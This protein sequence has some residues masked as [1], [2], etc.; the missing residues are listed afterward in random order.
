MVDPDSSSPQFATAFAV[1]VTFHVQSKRRLSETLRIL[2]A[3]R[4]TVAARVIAE[5]GDEI[6]GAGKL[7]V[8]GSHV[9]RPLPALAPRRALE[10]VVVNMER[11]RIAARA[12]RQRPQG[13]PNH[14]NLKR[15]VHLFRR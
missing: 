2:P 3:D 9:P 1:A 5:G 11:L 15:E 12:S 14:T 6:G 10:E 13:I 7:V 4:N 8:F